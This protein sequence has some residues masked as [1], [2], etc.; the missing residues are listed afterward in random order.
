VAAL[1]P[2]HTRKRVW[3]YRTR[4]D[5]GV[6][7]G[8]GPSASVTWRCQSLPTQGVGVEL[9]DTWRL[10]SPLLPGDGFGASGHMATPEPFPSGWRARCLGAR[11][12]TRALSWRVARSVPRGTWRHR[13]PL[14][15]GGVLCASG[16]VAEPELS[17]TGSRSRA[18]GLIF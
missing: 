12:D 8:G 15:V 1:K 6:L 14:L 7:P 3:S 2:S 17:G 9:R 10:W 4:G 18:V 11:D 13:S 16:H 5:T